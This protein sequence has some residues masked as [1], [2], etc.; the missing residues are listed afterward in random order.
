MWRSCCCSPTAKVASATDC[1]NVHAFLRVLRRAACFKP[2]SCCH[3]IHLA[4]CVS[5]FCLYLLSQAATAQDL[6][7]YASGCHMLGGCSSTVAAQEQHTAMAA[8]QD[9]IL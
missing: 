3:C 9:L 7:S 8:Q 6:S 4:C 1:S 2:R 5:F